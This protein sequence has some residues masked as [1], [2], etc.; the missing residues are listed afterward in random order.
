MEPKVYIVDNEHQLKHLHIKPG[1]EAVVKKYGF[2]FK[3]AVWF[4]FDGN[5]WV[6][7]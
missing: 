5:E 7:L 4:K 1:Q 2:I 3:R 6:K